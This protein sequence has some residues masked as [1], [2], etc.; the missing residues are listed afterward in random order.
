MVSLK[1][2]RLPGADARSFHSRI[3]YVRY[4]AGVLT[5]VSVGKMAVEIVFQ[6][7]NQADVCISSAPMN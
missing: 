4:S 2:R 5:K 3:F 1:G 6:G 7:D